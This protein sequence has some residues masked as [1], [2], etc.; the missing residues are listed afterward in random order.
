MIRNMTISELDST[1]NSIVEVLTESQQ[2][3]K[4]SRIVQ[5][6]HKS[7]GAIRHRLL[8]LEVLGLVKAVRE[9]ASTVYFLTDGRGATD[10]S[11]S[12]R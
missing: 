8:I 9:R 1:D 6:T 12:E 3:C 4:I 2:G 7:E 5:A 10:T 11:L